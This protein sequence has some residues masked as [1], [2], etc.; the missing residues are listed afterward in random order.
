MKK[1][2]MHKE[3]TTVKLGDLICALYEE[4]EKMSNNTAEQRF[5]VYAALKDMLRNKATRATSKAAA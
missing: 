4:A 3:H 2:G 1:N 5:M